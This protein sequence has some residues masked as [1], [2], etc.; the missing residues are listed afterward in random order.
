MAVGVRRHLLA[1]LALLIATLLLESP[2]AAAPS[3]AFSAPQVLANQGQHATAAMGPGGDVV[4]AWAGARGGVFAARRDA[5]GGPYSSAVRISDDRISPFDPIRLARNDRGDVAIA[6]IRAYTGQDSPAVVRVA[7]AAAGTRG[8]GAPQDVAS[9]EAVRHVAL[10]V[11]PDGTTAISFVQA[12]PPAGAYAA[13]RSAAGAVSAPQLLTSRTLGLGVQLA[14]TPDGGLHAIWLAD[15]SG[16]PGTTRLSAVN[17]AEARPGTTWGPAGRLSDPAWT[18]GDGGSGGLPQIVANRRGE[19]IATW[20]DSVPGSNFFQSR[21][22]VA[23]RRAGGGWSAPQELAG[24]FKVVRSVSPAI[25]DAGDAVVSWGDLSHVE[26]TFRPAGGRF[27]GRLNTQVPA[28]PDLEGMAIGLDALG[29]TLIVR[30]QVVGNTEG[31]GQMFALVRRRDA[32]PEP[33]IAISA[34]EQAISSPAIATDPFGNGVIVWTSRGG[35]QPV[36]AVAYSALPPLVARVRAGSRELRFR[37]SE[38]AKMRISVRR[39]VR[40][41]KSASQT[42]VAKPGANKVRYSSR[43]RKLLRKKGRYVAT[44]RTRDAGPR[45]STIKVRFRRR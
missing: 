38:P 16:A 20:A 18:S 28:S 14:A 13:Q 42:A 6:W 40:R 24:P 43:M 41:G 30:R 3:A 2:A 17:V 9:G 29:V 23:V 5:L 27:G 8:F 32:N 31:P 39:D 4:V 44:I 21:A 7:V 25:N 34:V 26:T 22:E 45:S 10:A 19:L 36:T 11:A 33:D 1:C 35:S 12:R 15:T 37:A